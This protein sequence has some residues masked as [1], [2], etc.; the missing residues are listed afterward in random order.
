MAKN[1][2]TCK[3]LEWVDGE[4]EST[5]GWDCNKRHTIPMTVA[6]ETALLDQLDSEAYRNRYKRCFTATKE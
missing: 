1:C 2:H 3:H 5:T 4:C 6:K